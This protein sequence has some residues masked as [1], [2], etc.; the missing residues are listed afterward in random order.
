MKNSGVDALA[1]IVGK[2]YIVG[3]ELSIFRYNKK[4]SMVF[5]SDLGQLEMVY[6]YVFEIDKDVD[7]GS[8]SLPDDYLNNIMTDNKTCN[9]LSP[10]NFA[11]SENGSRTATKDFRVLVDDLVGK[12]PKNE[13]LHL[14]STSTLMLADFISYPIGYEYLKKRYKR[15]G[16]LNFTYQLNG[17]LHIRIS[18]S[19]KIP[20]ILNTGSRG[21]VT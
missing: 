9:F 4:K 19:P 21:K 5:S 3:L 15:Y 11:F 2:R 20:Y 7:W 12:I 14:I 6:P 18:K 10:E 1:D 13:M 17:Y 16:E 8:I